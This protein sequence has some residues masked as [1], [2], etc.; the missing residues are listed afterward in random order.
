MGFFS[1]VKQTGGYVFNFRVTKWVGLDRLKNSSK[2][3]ANLTKSLYTPEQ[4][5]Y[6]E[7]F[8][9]ALKRLNITEAEINQRRV[10]FTRLMVIYM[11]IAI[12]LFS[13]S[14]YIVYVHKN[15]LGFFMGFSVTIFALS[16]AFRYHFWIFQIKNKKLGC[17]VRDWFLDKH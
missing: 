5:E 10:E 12:L 6:S 14:I 13:Y 9:E 1:R 16:H 15:I 17:S 4:A 11:L 7:T 2:N 8:E 3:L